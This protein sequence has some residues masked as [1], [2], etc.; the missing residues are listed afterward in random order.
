[1]NQKMVVASSKSS[2]EAEQILRTVKGIIN[3]HK[4]FPQL[5]SKI[6]KLDTYFLVTLSPIDSIPLRHTLSS[7]LQSTFSGMFIIENIALA[8]EKETG[9]QHTVIKTKVVKKIP[10]TTVE[11]K[12]TIDKT[13]STEK[14]DNKSFLLDLDSE[15]YALLALALAGFMLIMRSNRQIGKIKKLQ[16]E[17]EEV[18]KKN[19]T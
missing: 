8:D 11:P 3:E 13:I 16:M 19:D 18:Q 7:V 12:V 14:H 6:E 4:Q 17:L 15:W 10:E 9:I 1:M 2:S 5:D